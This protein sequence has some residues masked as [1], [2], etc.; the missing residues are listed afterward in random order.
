MVHDIAV[1]CPGKSFF[2]LGG[3]DGAGYDAALGQSFIAI[4]VNQAANYIPTDY[5]VCSDPV[6]PWGDR[7]FG[8]LCK[9]FV[10]NGTPKKSEATFFDRKLGELVYDNDDDAE[11]L[12]LGW[13]G[14]GSG[15]GIAL[16]MAAAICWKEALRYRI[17]VLGADF[18]DLR[19]ATEWGDWTYACQIPGAVSFARKAREVAN[20]FGVEL[21]CTGGPMS[22]VLPVVRWPD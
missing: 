18:E 19:P 17:I 2:A 4:A 8:N 12:C 3:K 21:C 6:W 16:A 14:P 11:S 9:V 1:F 10:P 20:K 13:W 7:P 5:V 22:E 15:A